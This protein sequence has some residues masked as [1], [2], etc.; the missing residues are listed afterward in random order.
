MIDLLVAN[1]NFRIWSKL[2][3]LWSQSIVKFTARYSRYC[4]D[5]VNNIPFDVNQLRIDNEN[6][7]LAVV[8]AVV[9]RVFFSEIRVI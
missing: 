9:V 1:L 8:I 6:T 4:E 5:S 3:S 7:S 2:W